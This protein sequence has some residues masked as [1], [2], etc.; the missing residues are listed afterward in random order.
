MFFLAWLICNAVMPNFKINSNTI[1]TNILVLQCIV[2]SN[3]ELIETIDSLAGHFHFR[4]ALG[5]SSGSS[6]QLLG[7]L[8]SAD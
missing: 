6:D 1:R 5:S 7:F 2:T 4:S 8:C 3:S